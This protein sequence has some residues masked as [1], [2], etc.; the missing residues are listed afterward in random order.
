MVQVDGQAK[1]EMG[2]WVDVGGGDQVIS[3]ETERAG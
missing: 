2:E 1:A 3:K